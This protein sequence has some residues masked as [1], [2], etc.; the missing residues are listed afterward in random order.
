[1]VASKADYSHK[2]GRKMIAKKKEDFLVQKHN[3]LQL[4]HRA[5]S[6]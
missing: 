3:W 1:M 2:K 4:G 6:F 5:D